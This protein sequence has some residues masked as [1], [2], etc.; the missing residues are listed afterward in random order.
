MMR[1]FQ[2]TFVAE[3][4]GLLGCLSDSR[5]ENHIDARMVLANPLGESE[6]IHAA[7]EQY[8]D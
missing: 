6:P 4:G 1:F 2:R 8:L 3:I 5:S 7:A